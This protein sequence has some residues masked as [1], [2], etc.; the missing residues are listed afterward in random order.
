MQPTVD[1][2]AFKL[3]S[4]VS[5]EA[6]DEPRYGVTNSD[7]DLNDI[8]VLL[9]DNSTLSSNNTLSGSPPKTALEACQRWGSCKNGTCVE[10]LAAGYAC[11][12]FEGFQGTFC[13]EK[14]DCNKTVAGCAEDVLS[15]FSKKTENTLSNTFVVLSSVSVFALMATAIMAF[16]AKRKKSHFSGIYVRSH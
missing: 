3:D 2:T 11:E 1:P 10:H 5:I 4:D 12:C 13:E 16:T 8:H 9:Q 15:S 7:Q 14:F 6:F